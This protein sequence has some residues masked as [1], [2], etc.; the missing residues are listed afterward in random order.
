MGVIHLELSAITYVELPS[1][2]TSRTRSSRIIFYSH[3]HPD[4]E[5]SCQLIRAILRDLVIISSIIL[6]RL[7]NMF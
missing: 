6:K 3:L 7:K 1:R 2:V 5:L 4:L